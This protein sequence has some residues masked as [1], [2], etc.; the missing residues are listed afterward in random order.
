[1][2][3]PSKA[4]VVVHRGESADDFVSIARRMHKMDTSVA[5]AMF[6]EHLDPRVLPAEFLNLPMLVVYLVNPPPT[7]FKKTRKIAV[8]EMSK[9]EEYQHF[10]AHGLPCMPIERF[11]WGMTL[12]PETYG[13]MVVLKP[14][15]VTST[16]ADI[17]MVP[18][19]LVPTLKP[20]DFPAGHL[21]HR[22][23]YLVQRFMKSGEHPT[24]FR[25]LVL[26]DQVLYSKR[27]MLNRTYPNPM[28]GLE[29][30]LNT[31]VA[32]N[33]WSER[34]ANL[35][36][37]RE[38]NAFALSVAKTFPDHPLFGI[39][40]LRNEDT[41]RLYVLEVNL[42]GNTWHF[43]SNV[44]RELARQGNTGFDA[45]ARLAMLQQY[46]AWDRAAEVLLR[47]TH[48]LAM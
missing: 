6:S 2:V 8:M 40:I 10:R 38:I 7:E 9:I 12:D 23:G 26:F 28:A 1:M 14:E 39:D 36:V 42:G 48:E 46:N 5:V 31:T 17:N 33:S 37:D 15:T 45:K 30:L 44:V 16:G 32:S 20:E 4:L 22:D 11:R 13:D 27:F 34:V 18:V 19:L 21:I 41:G 43:S 24:H 25:V 47:K 29:V 35:C 3:A